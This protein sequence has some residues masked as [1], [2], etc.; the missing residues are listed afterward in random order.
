[1]CDGNFRC[2]AA[3]QATVWLISGGIEEGSNRVAIHV[4]SLNEEATEGGVSTGRSGSKG[5]YR[6]DSQ[7]AKVNSHTEYCT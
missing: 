5:D 7:E 3:A 2:L 4:P 6:G 1:M